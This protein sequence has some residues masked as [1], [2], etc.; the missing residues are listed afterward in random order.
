MLNLLRYIHRCFSLAIVIFVSLGFLISILSPINI[1]VWDLLLILS[2]FLAA[3]MIYGLEGKALFE[4][5][6]SLGFNTLLAILPLIIF[7]PSFGSLFQSPELQLSYHSDLHGAYV[8]QIILGT[9]QAQN[10]YV[11]GEPANY[12]WLYYT[13]LASVSHLSKLPHSFARSIIDFILLFST[14]GWIFETLVYIVPRKFSPFTLMILAVIG[15]SGLNLFGFLHSMVGMWDNFNIHNFFSLITPEGLYD[16]LRLRS[17]LDNYLSYSSASF[18]YHYSFVCIYAMVASVQALQLEESPKALFWFFVATAGSIAF[19][20]VG[21]FL[22]PAVIICGWLGIGLFFFSRERKLPRRYLFP[23]LT[24]KDLI[25]LILSAS[26]IVI[27]LLYFWTTRNSASTSI[28]LHFL[29]FGAFTAIF[30]SFYPL[31]P[32]YFVAIL[33]GWSEKNP[34]L[35]GLLVSS[36]V[37]LS[38][39]AFVKIAT[40]PY[41]NH[42]YKFVIFSSFFVAFSALPVIDRFQFSIKNPSG[43]A[44]LISLTKPILVVFFTA[45]VLNTLGLWAEARDRNTA[46]ANR[47]GHYYEGSVVLS[48]KNPYQDIYTWLRT[49]TPSETIILLPLNQSFE[50]YLLSER[51]PYVALSNYGLGESSSLYSVYVGRLSHLYLDDPSTS[52]WQD[53]FSEICLT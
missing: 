3:T 23:S 50:T 24:K 20:L 46:W 37:M 10:P 39:A 25:F 53:N 5:K 22:V 52:T 31:F 8:Q 28:N 21:G 13:I 47:R 6:N 44:R 42:E 4:N 11:L 45:V 41:A 38:I 51:R 27:Q 49:E 9:G 43:S 36:F 34:I 7:L 15:F 1:I 16:S 32:L 14:I 40:E 17:N 33:V 2:F 26:F 18:G 35:I 30:G 12:P 48:H 19:L 29:N